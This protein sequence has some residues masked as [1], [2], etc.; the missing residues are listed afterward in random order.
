MPP[1]DDTG[2]VLVCSFFEASSKR[3]NA[4]LTVWP[5]AV[6][7][8]SSEDDTTKAWLLVADRFLLLAVGSAG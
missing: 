4:K 5:A 3:A 8:S 6:E 1:P 2:A 7:E